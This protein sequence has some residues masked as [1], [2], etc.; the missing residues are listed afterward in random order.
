MQ[1]LMPTHLCTTQVDQ[2]ILTAKYEQ[3]F[4]FLHSYFAVP[5]EIIFCLIAYSHTYMY[6]L[7]F[8]KNNLRATNKYLRAA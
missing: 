1:C 4:H 7:Y 5:F 2:I 8:K 6:V 3:F